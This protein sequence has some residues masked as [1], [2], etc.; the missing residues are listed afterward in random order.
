MKFGE[1][2]VKV[3]TKINMI[4]KQLWVLIAVV[5]ASMGVQIW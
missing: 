2:M 1:R 5:L 4:E 3:E